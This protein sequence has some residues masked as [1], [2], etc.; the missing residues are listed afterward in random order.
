[1]QS[2]RVEMRKLLLE[3]IFAAIIA[4]LAPAQDYLKGSSSGRK[5]SV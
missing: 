2:R 5:R 3:L 1:M 4:V